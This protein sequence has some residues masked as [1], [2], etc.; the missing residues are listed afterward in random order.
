MRKFVFMGYLTK[1]KTM[2]ETHAGYVG[3]RVTT[4]RIYVRRLS[5]ISACLHQIGVKKCK[6][7]LE[8]AV[9]ARP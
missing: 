3:F 9:K 4:G 8:Q 5:L 6:A 1:Y 2:K 7:V